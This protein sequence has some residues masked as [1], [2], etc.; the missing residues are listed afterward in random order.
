MNREGLIGQLWQ[1]LLVLVVFVI[2]VRLAAVVI[3][4]AMG[5][6]V[7]LFGLITVYAVLLGRHR[8]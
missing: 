7:A 3:A 5:A 6:V 1:T 8:R 2:V 4:P